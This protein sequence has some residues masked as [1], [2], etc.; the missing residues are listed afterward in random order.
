MAGQKVKVLS[1]QERNVS[2]LEKGVY[3]LTIATDK[4]VIAD[5]IIKE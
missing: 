1:Q 5:K 3:F 4:G 2:D